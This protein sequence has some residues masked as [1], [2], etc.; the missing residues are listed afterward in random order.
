LGAAC[1]THIYGVVFL[2]CKPRN[3]GYQVLRYLKTGTLPFKE[4]S[5]DWLINSKAYYLSIWEKDIGDGLIWKLLE[6]EGK[7]LSFWKKRGQQEQIDR[8]L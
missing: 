3:I 1:L 8:P 6:D 2:F 7:R 4:Y 5:E